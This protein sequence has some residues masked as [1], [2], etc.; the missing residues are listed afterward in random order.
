MP[1][2]AAPFRGQRL[3]VGAVCCGLCGGGCDSQQATYVL[4]RCDT[5]GCDDTNAAAAYH[6]DCAAHYVASKSPGQHRAPH[7]KKTAAAKK[8]TLLL[9]DVQKGELTGE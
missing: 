2:R 4:V 6:L 8:A 1:P 9:H 3:Q 5:A 7:L